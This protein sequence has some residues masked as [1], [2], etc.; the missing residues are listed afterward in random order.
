[1][2]S[3]VKDEM[4]VQCI[5][6]PRII[7]KLQIKKKSKL[8]SVFKKKTT[9][10]YKVF[11][12]TQQ[13]KSSFKYFCSLQLSKLIYNG[14]VFIFCFQFCLIFSPL[15]VILLRCAHV[16]CIFWFT[17]GGLT[18]VEM[19]FLWMLLDAEPTSW[20]T[21]HNLSTIH[22]VYTSLSRSASFKNIIL[23]KNMLQR[24]TFRSKEK[25]P[26][27][28]KKHNKSSDNLEEQKLTPDAWLVSE[29][30]R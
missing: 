28:T 13:I 22:T 3:A 1:M 16:N 27:T 4:K 25:T 14:L 19:F 23:K 24:D 15:N 29:E 2:F 30:R 18:A 17:E 11:K 5:K 20:L 26:E 21:K 12:H 6:I 9:F 7:R 10:F 8:R